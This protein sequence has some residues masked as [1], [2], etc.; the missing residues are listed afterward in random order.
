MQ[1]DSDR[2]RRARSNPDAGGTLLTGPRGVSDTAP[3][4]TKTLLG[5]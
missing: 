1:G 5:E 4:A 3:T 2:R